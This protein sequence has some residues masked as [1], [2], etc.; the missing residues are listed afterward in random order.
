M[1]L[2]LYLTLFTVYGL[3]IGSFLNV[4]AYRIPIGESVAKGRSYCPSCRHSLSA[5]DLVPVF[6]YLLLGRRCRYCKSTISPRY[7][8]VELLTAVCFGAA[9]L[10]SPSMYL[11]V[12][13]CLLMAVLIV[14]A[15]IDAQTQEISDKAVLMVFALA[16]AVFAAQWR[17]DGWHHILLLKLIGIFA[18]SL[19]MLVIARFTGGFGG[20]DIKLMAAAGLYLG[21]FNIVLAFFIGAVLAAVYGLL[22]IIRKK[23]KRKSAIAFG[24]FLSVGIAVSL[25]FGDKMIATYLAWFN[26]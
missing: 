7:A 23:F 5:L 22:L 26:L 10:F 20:G 25:L 6:S 1:E 12:F 11:A 9:Y 19:P 13:N 16:A 2:Y 21:V 3:V 14:V 18:V 15:L 17:L 4:C 8:M 24:P